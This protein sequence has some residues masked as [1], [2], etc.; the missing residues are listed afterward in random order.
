[1]QD[2]GKGANRG[3]QGQQLVARGGQVGVLGQARTEAAKVFPGVTIGPVECE[4]R[5]ARRRCTADQFV[6]LAG[7]D[8]DVAEQRIAEKLG[9]V[10]EQ[11]RLLVAREGLKVD[12]EAL[13]ELEQE[14]AVE[15]ALVVLDQV[16]VAGRYAQA[17]GHGDLGQALPV[18]Q[19]AHPVAQHGLSRHGRLSPTPL[20]LVL[21]D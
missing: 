4:D 10:G 3:Q 9:D 17:R 18:A 1:M 20:V 8:L 19:P 14:R 16:Q 6:Q 2:L 21:F 7:L 5:L 15:A 13:R 11:P 12:I